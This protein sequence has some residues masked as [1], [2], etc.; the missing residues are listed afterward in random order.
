M[1]K[2]ILNFLFSACFV[3][4]AFAQDTT[5][6]KKDDIQNENQ[7]EEVKIVKQKKAIEQKPDRTIFNISDQPNL[8][9]GTLME[10][11]KQLP[12]LISSDVAGM[13]YQGKQLEVFLDGRPLNISSAE[14][15]SFL[16][17]MPANSV[18]RI[19]VITQPGAE[20]PATSGG[21]ILNII[22]KKTEENIRP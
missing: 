17:G 20:F 10:T 6:V 21:A 13:L 12:G 8:N 14:L 11:I 4:F 19:E 15:N 18:E 2:L 9:A 7:I 5:K 16:E 22:T 1:K 3:L